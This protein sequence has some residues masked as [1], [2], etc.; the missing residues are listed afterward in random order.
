LHGFSR[1]RKRLPAKL[2]EQKSRVASLTPSRDVPT[3]ILLVLLYRNG[4]LAAFN[5]V[6]R[7][8]RV[9]RCVAAAWEVQMAQLLVFGVDS[10]QTA[11]KVL[12][13]TADLNRQELL[14]ALHRDY[15]AGPTGTSIS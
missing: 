7:L 9:L 13:L 11:E 8:C 2:S 3:A 12:D 14:Q 15:L 10:P 1:R 5:P 6:R 4:S